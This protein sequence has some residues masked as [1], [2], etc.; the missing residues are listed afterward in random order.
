MQASTLDPTRAITVTLEREYCTAGETRVD[1]LDEMVAALKAQ[2]ASIVRLRIC[3]SAREDYERVG[4]VV[5][6]LNRHGFRIAEI[7]SHGVVTAFED[8]GPQN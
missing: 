8:T 6:G 2:Q 7:D 5:Y 3:H 4:K 1:S